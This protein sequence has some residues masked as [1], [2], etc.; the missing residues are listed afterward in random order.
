MLLVSEDDI[1]PQTIGGMEIR[2]WEVAQVMSRALEVVVLTKA[3]VRDGAGRF[4]K[5]DIGGERFLRFSSRFSW[6]LGR[7]ALRAWGATALPPRIRRLVADLRPDYLYFN[8]FES[9]HPRVLRA[10]VSQPVP[11][12]ARFGNSLGDRLLDALVAARA[13]AQSR[14]PLQPRSVDGTLFRAAP[15]ESRT[16]VSLVFNCDFL[17]RYYEGLGSDEFGR[18]RSGPCPET[19]RRIVVYDG[20]DTDAFHPVG[21]SPD[22][23]VF[24][25]LGRTAHSNKGF[26][27]FCR[28]MTT[29]PEALVG[30]IEIIGY[31]EDFQSGLD[32]IRGAGR[33]HLLRGAGKASREEVA[34]RLRTGSIVVLPTRDEGLPA[35]LMEAMATGLPV[36][37]SRVAGIPEVVEDGA[38]GLLVRKADF[39]DL[40]AACRRLAEDGTLRAR[41]GRAARA[42]MV[43]RFE[44]EVGLDHLTR[45][46]EVTFGLRVETSTTITHVAPPVTTAKKALL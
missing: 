30:G 8:Q 6:R 16:P 10:L 7:L 37:A 14:E 11:V 25:F 31:G 13:P 12:V 46:T 26:L 21:I 29:L 43:S 20:V 17:R 42:L 24:V 2:G 18:R 22:P 32:V 5:A 33:S 35:A 44:R 34:R 41:L 40:L 23:P 39:A 19:F 15:G 38:T 4:R 45:V 9:L 3:G 1:Y 27:D 28:A 36:V